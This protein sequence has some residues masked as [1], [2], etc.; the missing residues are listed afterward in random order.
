MPKRSST[1]QDSMLLVQASSAICEKP[2]LYSF[3]REERSTSPTNSDKFHH[4]LN[5]M[6]RRAGE[7]LHCSKDAAKGA[8]NHLSLLKNSILGTILFVLTTSCCANQRSRRY[9]E[10][11]GRAATDRV[12]VLLL[13]PRGSDSQRSPSP[14]Y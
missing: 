10:D 14:T 4:S 11:D 12:V 3:S 6:K 7:R 2:T 13:S 1:W 5:W 8:H 9:V